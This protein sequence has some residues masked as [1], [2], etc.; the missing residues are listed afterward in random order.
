MR[1][2][3]RA[4]SK[5]SRGHLASLLR[6]DGTPLLASSP[7]L[8]SMALLDNMDLQQIMAGGDLPL[9][10]TSPNLLAPGRTSLPR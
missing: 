5:N 2:R 8:K 7:Y 4:P 6:P 9:D 1:T 10:P 3:A